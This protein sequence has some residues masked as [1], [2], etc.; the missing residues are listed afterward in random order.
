MKIG[1]V[2]HVNVSKRERN[3]KSNLQV[4]VGGGIEKKSGAA[5]VLRSLFS[6]SRAIC[7]NGP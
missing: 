4:F 7:T 3:R 5:A 2:N 6:K 1:V